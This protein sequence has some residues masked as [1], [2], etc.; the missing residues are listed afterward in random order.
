MSPGHDLI[1]IPFFPPRM[2]FIVIFLSYNI[3]GMNTNLAKW[4]INCLYNVQAA[5]QLKYGFCPLDML[6]NKMAISR[7]RGHKTKKIRVLYFLQLLKFEKA[8]CPYFGE[9]CFL[10]RVMAIL[11]FCP[12]DM[13]FDILWKSMSRGQ[14][15]KMTVSRLRKH[16]MQK[17]GHFAFSNFKSWRK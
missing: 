7:K 5:G 6:F 10:S 2:I 8:K 15:Q 16:K 11:W 9:I 3:N 12:L 1:K 4:N 17:Q 14:N 13:L